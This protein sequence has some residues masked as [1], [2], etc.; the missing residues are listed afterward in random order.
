MT[1]LV[2]PIRSF[3]N[4]F[5][6]LSTRLD[7]DARHALGKRLADRV[8][9]A[10]G[11]MAVFIVSSDADVVAWARER[12]ATIVDDPG[13]LDG[14]ADAGRAFARER[15]E[16]RVVVAHA[17]LPFASALDRFATPGPAPTAMIVPDRAGDG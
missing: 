16:D 14:A 6:R 12:S 2:V 17:D 3:R 11:A 1:V 13:S 9:D 5:A 7:D 10:A 15:G 4:G 8:V